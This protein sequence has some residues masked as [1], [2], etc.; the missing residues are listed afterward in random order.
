MAM[1]SIVPVW[2]AVSLRRSTLV[3]AIRRLSAEL[4]RLKVLM[5]AV[6]ADVMGSAY[7]GR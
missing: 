2:A 3:S 1:G 4:H 7:V 6:T 5:A